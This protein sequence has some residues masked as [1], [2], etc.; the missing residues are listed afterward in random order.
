MRAGLVVTLGT[1]LGAATPNPDG[2]PEAPLD[3]RCDRMQVFS[4][5]NR[6]LCHDNVVV[7]RGDLLVCCAVFE[8]LADEDW[9][10]EKFVCSE[11]VRAQRTDETM[12]S[13]RAEFVLATHELLLTGRP[14]LKRGKSVLSG[15][16]VIV[17]VKQ[18]HARIEKPRGHFEA[19]RPTA[20]RTVA[21]ALTGPLPALCPLPPTP[22]S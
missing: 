13:D 22:G 4:K 21:P 14:L 7:R 3:F 19:S 6:T 18:D 12:W 16:R 9:G 1:V 8:G 15:Q 10:W 17:D 11:N 20:T 2:A 5:P